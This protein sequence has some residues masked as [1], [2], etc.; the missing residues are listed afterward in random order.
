MAIAELQSVTPIWYTQFINICTKKWNTSIA[1]LHHPKDL[2]SFSLSTAPLL[3]LEAKS[4]L[5]TQI[6]IHIHM[7][8]CVKRCDG[9]QQ[10]NNISWVPAGCE[11]PEPFK[12]VGEN[13]SLCLFLSLLSFPLL[14]NESHSVPNLLW[15]TLIQ[16]DTHTHTKVCWLIP[17]CCLFILMRIKTFNN[18][19]VCT[20]CYDPRTH[21]L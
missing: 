7:S 4:Q 9:L 8:W 12:F 18:K 21:V 11:E 20:S 3:S 10:S 14:S 16:R 2:L 15:H 6:H 17:I 19:Q 13:S 1:L 5:N